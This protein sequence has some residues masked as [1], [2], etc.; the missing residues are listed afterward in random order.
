VL[1]PIAETFYSIQGEGFYAGTAAY[2]IRLAGCNLSCPWCDTD[3]RETE[4]RTA[5]ELS[6]RAGD[7][8]DAR[9]AVLT[10]GEPLLHNLFPLI[11]SLRYRGF[12]V[13]IE[14]NGTRMHGVIG[15]CDWLTVSP[16]SGYDYDLATLFGDE[17]KIVLDGKIDPHRF[18]SLPFR[19]FFVQPCSGDHAPAIRFVKENP[20]WRLSLQTQKLINIR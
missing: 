4:R 14:T 15:L 1:Y 11:D 12:K 20:K 2:F 7:S 6:I 9:L 10:G 17:I 19:Q 18:E 13:A 8:C 16:K 5:Q 3:H